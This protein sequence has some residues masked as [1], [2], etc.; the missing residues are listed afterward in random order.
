MADNKYK[1]FHMATPVEE[2]NTA[3]WAN[4]HKTKRVSKVIVPNRRQIKNA[5]EYVDTNEK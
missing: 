1:K 4:I 2:H 5:K 3:A